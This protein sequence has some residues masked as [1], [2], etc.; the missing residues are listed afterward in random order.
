[1]AS[2]PLAG[3][4]VVTPAPRYDAVVVGAGHNGLVAGAYLARAGRRVLIL[5]RRPRVGGILAETELAAGVKVPALV[6]TVGRLRS[7]VVRDLR[8]DS[9][10]LRLIRPEVRAFAPDGNGGAVTLWADPARTAEGLRRLSRHDGAAYADFDA[11]ARAVASFVAHLHAATPP[12]IQTPSMSDAITGL[13]LGRAFRRLGARTGREALRVLPMAVADLVGEAFERDELRG[14]IASRGVQF[15]AMGPWTAG[16]AAVLLADSAG[17][18]GGAAGQTAY[19]QGGPQALAEAM[20][21]AA[22]SFGAEVRTDADVTS[23]TTVDGRATGVALATGEE[24]TARIVVSAADPKQTLLALVDPEEL[25]PSLVWRASNIRMPGCTAKVNLALSGVPRFAGADER[26]TLCGRI[27]V[28]PGVDYLERGADA[29]KYRRMSAEPYLEAT[30]PSLVDPTL[31]PEGQH[32]MSVIVQWAPYRLKDTTWEKEREGLGDLVVKTLDAYAPGL[33]SLI[34]ARQVLTPVDLERDFG[35]TGGHVLHGEPGLDQFFAWRPLLGFARYRMPI[36]GLY[37][38]G[39]GAHPGGGVTG[40]PG[41]NAAREI[42]A[43][44]KRHRR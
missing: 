15:T 40:A 25:G 34:T 27:L 38:C 22:R 33:S 20:A 14:V 29:A 39:S 23:V 16:T 5:E 35:L 31:A 3:D 30:I 41:S 17:S 12:E 24:V 2:G 6:H 42:L 4:G 37:L 28:A 13:K 10:G 11:R 9:H 18:D 1:V 36:R 26:E 32:V 43:D 8:L 7:S 21:S 19:A 44:L